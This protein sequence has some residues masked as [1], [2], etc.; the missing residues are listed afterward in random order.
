MSM[1]TPGTYRLVSPALTNG[2]KHGALNDNVTFNTNIPSLDYAIRIRRVRWIANFT[3]AANS[4]LMSVAN[5]INL[6]QFFAQLTENQTKTSVLNTDTSYLDMTEEDFMVPAAQS[7]AAG[8]QDIFFMRRDMVIHDFDDP[9]TPYTVATKL[10][11]VV[12]GFELAGALSASAVWKAQAQIEYELV[13]LTADLRD[14]LA[15][16]LQI[17]GS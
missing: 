6:V 14:Y 16:R 12:S 15:K 17:Q 5:G 10:N 1:S 13:R 3:N 9:Q 11:V 7:T 8:F 4:E 2:V